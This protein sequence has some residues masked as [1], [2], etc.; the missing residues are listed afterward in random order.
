M[1]VH[2]L[3]DTDPGIDDTLALLLA[4]RAPGG[5]VEAVTT[6]SG[7]VPVAVAT[8]NVARIFGVVQP[9]PAP[10]VAAGAAEPRVRPLVTATHV[11][12][13]DGLGGLS[14]LTRPDGR[15]RFPEASLRLHPRDAADLIVESARRWPG[16]LVIVALGPL[17]NLAQA[18]DRGAEALQ[19]VRA[20]VVMGGAVAVGGNVTAAA[21]FNMFV[22]PESAAHVLGADLPITLVP[23]DVTERV[24]WPAGAVQHLRET[25]D[26]VARF[27]AAVAERGLDLARSFGAAGIT[28]HDPLAVGV[29]LDPT[30]VETVA[31]PVAVETGGTLARGV[32]VADRRRPSPRHSS[33]PN[34]RVALQV[35]AAR[36]LRMF[37]ERL[38]PGSV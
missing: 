21:E 26:P 19:R 13:E 30:L 20:V 33:R 10:V 5:R 22:D 7:N 37:E 17:T 32:T 1:T 24:V 36:F 35:D 27:A 4:L 11:H 2:L 9:T 8:R 18:V 31:L 16:E 15:P 34:C 23:L 25:P 14:G 28:M 38:W 6:V 12:G 3:I 29:A